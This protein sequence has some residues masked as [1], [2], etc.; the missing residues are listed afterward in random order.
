MKTIRVTILAL[1]LLFATGSF[2]SLLAFSSKKVAAGKQAVEIE[3]CNQHEKFV[4]VIHG[5]AGTYANDKVAVSCTGHG[6]YFI[7]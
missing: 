1:C 7:R 5:G 2:T 3:K 4:L 6:E